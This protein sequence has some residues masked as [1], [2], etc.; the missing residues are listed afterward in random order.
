VK[1]SARWVK[2][3][4]QALILIIIFGTIYVAVQQ[5]WRLSADQLPLRLAA[6][7]T[8]QIAGGTDPKA[9]A[10][11][12]TDLG[13]TLEPFVIVYDKDKKVAASSGK[14]NGS[15]PSPPKGVFD[16]I[17]RTRSQ[18]RFTWEP[19]KGYRYATVVQG[20]FKDNQVQYYVL[21]AQTL[22]ETEAQIKNL[23]VLVGAGWILSLIL[24]TGGAFLTPRLRK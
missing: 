20:V 4:L 7:A 21:A 9:I 16:H 17:T 23:T 19:A 8:Q 13:A 2:F 6:L 10:E 22:R 11:D 5:N 3:V 14:L 18:E 24:L 12:S 1:L 15:V